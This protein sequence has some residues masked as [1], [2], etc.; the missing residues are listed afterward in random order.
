MLF[1][2]V[3]I[4]HWSYIMYLSTK[5]TFVPWTSCL[6]PCATTSITTISQS[7]FRNILRRWLWM[8][9]FIIDIANLI[10]ALLLTL[11]LKLYC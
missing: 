4:Q 3:E 8:L 2:V 9:L 10:V 11:R 6:V 7:S 5:K 1:S